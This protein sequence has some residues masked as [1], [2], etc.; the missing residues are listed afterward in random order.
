M[1]DTPTKPPLTVSQQWELV[2]KTKAETL[3]PPT[4]E[5]K[6]A[7]ERDALVAQRETPKYEKHYTPGGT[8]EKEV[9]NAEAQKRE[10]KIK[11]IN[12]ALQKASN[13]LHNDFDKARDDRSH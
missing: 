2:Q 9:H 5:M 12:A 8:V 13:G 3:T 10:T 7:K 6:T 4:P 11:E 1:T